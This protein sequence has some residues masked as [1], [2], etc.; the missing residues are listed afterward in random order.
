[1]KE[2]KVDAAFV[3]THRFDNV[4]DR[5]HVK[6]DDFNVLWKSPV[7]PQDPFVYRSDLCPEL[8]KRSRTPSSRSTR[9]RRPR[10]SWTTSSP[11]KFVEMNDSRLRRH[12]GPA[13][14]SKPK[15]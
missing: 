9:T 2:G 4:I 7:I 6:L 5:G 10:S 3:A 13:E 14:A 1:M 8:K 15:K 12:R 11:T